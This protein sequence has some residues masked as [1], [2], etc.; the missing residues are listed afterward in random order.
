MQ[1]DLSSF[2]VTL[3]ESHLRISLTG[4]CQIGQIQ[5][6]SKAVAEKTTAQCPPVLI[7]GRALESLS[8]DWVRTLVQLRS[9]LQGQ[10]TELR[11]LG[12]NFHSVLRPHGLEKSF[13]ICLD[14][15]TALSE[16]GVGLKRSLNT[17]F[18]NPFLEATIKVLSVQANIEAIPEA[19]FLKQKESKFKGDV[20]GVI[21]IVSDTFT[22]SV[23][24]SF[25]QK[26]F[27]KLISGMLGET[28][29]ELN[30]DLIDGAA[31]LT[32]MIYGQAKV[33]L[34]EKGYAMKSAIPTV[35]TG[36][37]HSLSQVSKGAT[38]VIPFMTVVGEFYVEVSLAQ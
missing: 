3:Y 20:S 9:K 25:P 30:D 17:E 2:D 1:K 5:S 23:V 11:L 34:N 24:I 37:D 10:G 21:G 8:H 22:G 31:E 33:A 38:V 18:I 35:V 15:R 12:M 13:K 4:H 19:I 14:E 36:K 26:T 28:F 7:D 6:F 16:M 32:N 29:I 27:L